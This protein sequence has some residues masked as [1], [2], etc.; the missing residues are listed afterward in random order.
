MM[1]MMMMI[2]R[3]SGMDTDCQIPAASKIKTKL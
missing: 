3:T 2:V 1:M